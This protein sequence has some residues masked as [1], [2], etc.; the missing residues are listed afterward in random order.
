MSNS[1]RR[2]ARLF[3]ALLSFSI[4][5]ATFAGSI[6]A[7]AFA[8]EA[9]PSPTAEPSEPSPT[10]E[11]SPTTD[12]SP[13]DDPAPSEE[14]SPTEDPLPTEDPSPTEEPSPTGDPGPECDFSNP[15]AGP[16][17][18]SIASDLAD[19]PPG[20]EVTLTAA[21]FA[22]GESVC[23]RVNE[24]NPTETWSL[25]QTLSAAADGTLVFSFNLPDY[26]IAQYR[27]RAWGLESGA[28]AETTFTDSAGSYD[29]DFAAADPGDSPTYVK[30]T[31]AQFGAC[32]APS[33][34]TGRASDPMANAI[35]G[36]PKDAV[37][38]L[39]PDDM[40]L[41]QI[42]PFELDIDVDGSTSPET[43]K[44][45]I[46][47]DHAMFTTNGDNFG[48][49]S[50]FGVYCAFIDTNDTRN[51]NMDGDEKVVAFSSSVVGAGTNQEI[52]GSYNIS[53]LQDNDRVVLEIW[54]VLKSTI[55]AG[56]GGNVQSELFDADTCPTQSG[57]TGCSASGPNNPANISTG[58]QTVPLLQVGQ[59]FSSDANLGVTKT[60]SPDP[61]TAGNNLTYTIQVT[62]AGPDTAN[63]IVVTDVLDPNT[64]YVSS[65]IPCTGTTTLT[66]NAGNLVNGGSTSFTITVNVATGA[67]SGTTPGTSSIGGTCTVGSQDLCNVVSVDAINDDPT[68]GNNSDSEPTNVL[69]ANGS[70]QIL[71]YEDHDGNGSR[72]ADGADNAVGGG[73]DEGPL[74]GWTIFYD[75]NG[76]GQNDD[77]I[78][79]STDAS[80][81]VTLSGIPAGSASICEVLQSGWE[82]TDPGTVCQTVTVSGGGTTNEQFGNASADLA[83]DKTGPTTAQAGGV[84]EWTITVTNGG[85]SVATDAIADDSL[86][87]GVTNGRFCLPATSDCSMEANY[88][89]IPGS[90][91]I[92]LGDLS[93]GAYT[94][95]VRADVPGDTDDGTELENC[96]AVSSDTEDP[97]SNDLSDCHTTVVDNLPS[98]TVV[99]T[100][101]DAADGDTYSISEPGGTVTYTVTITNN[102]GEAVTLESLSDNVYGNL[103]DDAGNGLISNADCDQIGSIAPGATENC[104][105]DTSFT[106]DAGDS[107]VDTVTATTDDGEGN[108]ATDSD[109][110]TVTI[111]DDL[112]TV[113]VDKTADPIEVSEPG[114]EITYTYTVTNTSADESVTI[115]SLEDDVLGPL[116]GD[117]DCQVGTVLAAGANCSFT[118]TGN[119]AGT[120]GD[121][122]TNVFT[123]VVSDDNNNTDDDTDDATVTITD[124]LPTVDVDKTADPIEV[125]EPGGEITYTYTVTN[126]SADESVT[127]DSLED[128]VLG[129][130]AGDADCQ[131]G[132]VLAA[133]ANCSFT[134]TGNVAGTG[135]DSVTNVFT[136]VVSDDNNNT[137]DD[138]D[139]ATV[140]ITDDLPTVDVDKTAD[141]IEVSEP[142]GEITY[143]YTVTNTSADESV[144]IDSLEDDVLGPL[145]GDA[146]CQVGTVLAAGAN[147]SFTATGNVAGTGGDS[148]T[149]VFTAVV[150]DDNNNTDDDTD[151]ATVTITDDLPTVDVDKTADPIEVSEP[152]GEITY[153]YTVTNTSADES[154][155]ID[156]LEDDVLGPLAGDADCQVGTVLAAGANCSFTA[157]GNVAGTGGDSVTNV[158]TAVVSDD[159]NNTDDD[160]DDATV[161]ITDDLPTVDVDKTADPIE[162]SEPGGEITYTYTVTNTSADE[163]VTIDSLEDDVLGPLAGDADCQVGTVLAAGANCSFT[164]TGNVAG[165]G[166]DSVTNVFT[167][168]VSDDNN[169]T[170][171][172]TDDATVTIT[173]DLPTVDVDKTADPI[174][175]SEP[176]GEITYTY[177]VTNTSADESV[178]ID[179]LEDDVLGP[180]AGDADCQVGTVLAAGANCSFTA[181]GN[182]AGTGGDSVTNVFTAVVSDDN[183]NTDDDTDDA[184]VT[185]TDDLPTVDV[186]KTADPIEVSEPGGEITYTYTVT[187]TSADESVTI[188]SLEDDVLGPLAGDAD[189]QV[190][191]V[192]AAGANCSFTATGNVA[193]TGGDSVTNVFTAVVSDD[194]NN[195]DDDTDDATVTITDDLPTVDVDKTADPIEVSEPGGEITYTYTV[196]NT[197]ADESVTIDSL[198][199]DVLGP[200][201][202]DA[203]CQ[204]GTVLAAG[205]NCSFTATGNVAGTGGD[206]VTNVFTAVVSDD[207]NN[208]DDDTD[209]ATVTITDD[210]PTVDVDKTAD[211]IEV[212]EPGG[213]ITYTYTVTNTSADESVTIDSLEDDVLGPLAGDADCQ[214]G[215][216][217]AAG[218][219]CSFTA[220][221]NVAGTGGDSVTNVFTAVVSDDNNNTDDD[222]DDA[223]VT[224]TDDLPTVD[225]D[226]TADPIE[227]SEPGGEITYTY[228]VTNTSADESVTIDSLED[229][230]LGPLAGDADCQVGTVLAA[231]ANC[232]FTATGNVAGTGGDSVT[233]VFT[234]V[235]SDDNNNTDDDTDDAT[236]TITDDLPTVDVD[237][238]ADPIEVS[239]P[240]G[241]ITYTYTVTNTSA[242]ESVTIDSLED[243]VLGPLAG[244]ADCQVGTVL[245]AGANCS[246]T[247]TGNVAGTGGDSVTNVFTAV[248]SDDN[249][250]TDDDTDDATVTITD[251]L[252]TV[253]VDKT[254]DP[255]EVSEPGGEI[256]YTYTVT[257]T[258]ADESVTIDSLEDDVLGPLAGDAD[259]QVGTV[260]AAGANCSF[261][262]TGNVAGTG[263]DS[264]TNVFTAVVSDDNNNTDDDTDD[265]TVTIT[266]DLPTVDV[267]KTADPI[268][269]SEPGGEITYTYTVT[270]T[271]ADESVTI[272]SL[273]DDVLGPLAGDADCQVGTVLA[274][275]AN[276]SFTA[277]GNVAGTGG[278]SVTNVF[279]AVVSDDNNNTDDDTD[280]ATVTITD[281]LP[282]VDVDKTAD[283]IEV[284]E[285]GGEITY[286]YTVT[287]TSA[288]ESVTIDSLED[289][290]LGPLAGDADCQVGTV[291]AAGANCSFTATGNVAGTGGDSVTNVFTAVV[292]DDNN[293]TDD[294]TDD[295][296][297]TITDDLPTVDVDK[298][299]DPI[300]VSEP[301]GEITYTYTVTNTSADESVTIDSLED[302]VLGPLAGDADCQV[303]TVLAAGAN[304]SFTATGNVAG[305]GGDSVTNVFTAVV[306]DDNNNTDDDT[307]DATVTITDELPDISVEK[308][309]NPTSVPL[310]GGNVTFTIQVTNDSVEPVTL[311]VLNDSVFGNL[312]GRG[313]CD[314][315]Q[316]IAANGGTYT[317]SFVVFVTPTFNYAGQ[318]KAHRNVVTATA[319]D[320]EG[321]RDT[322]TDDAEVLFTW[323]GRT[324][325]YWKNHPTSWPNPYLT[326]Q[327]VQDVFT[328]PSCLKNAAGN[329]DLTKPSGKDT[330][331]QAL[332]YQGGTNLKGKAQ[333]LLR[334]AVA[335]LLNE[336]LFGADYPPHA[337]TTALIQDVNA[338][339]ATCNGGQY[340]TK[341]AVLDFWNNGIH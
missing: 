16:A 147:C 248:V 168:V 97:D 96:V 101:G 149:N 104:T 157:T 214:V 273:E 130:L 313:N 205:A 9:D 218:A 241:E 121:S 252:P 177:T 332:D 300:E 40:I 219:N 32:P 132:T 253:D 80:G 254:A 137:D 30:Q 283:P 337:S 22:P 100:A 93:P 37:E 172:D 286:T 261:T 112:P 211:P 166:G 24:D 141:P 341:A 210:L 107:V 164:A 269:V 34:G 138:T 220:T 43:G 41:G 191:T 303:G 327:K 73:D 190:G 95:R 163:S 90:G 305:T 307:D 209:D 200:L 338:T 69:A 328:I 274:A 136:A 125:S 198:E 199:D 319:V 102:S 216:V 74:Q 306:S 194:N 181:T 270:N 236:V 294:D 179:S 161:T 123:A 228:T 10:E 323:R 188:D 292:S 110:A 145:A 272:D 196:T 117:A 299:A 204:V 301:G 57:S 99:K 142:G 54:L 151:D 7:T 170:D 108:D 143:T 31:P 265:A 115:D 193:G 148:V 45:R 85:P 68:A 165:T 215:T 255:I 35:F 247:A 229:D 271:S 316:T 28:Y 263:G 2:S 12:P 304:C 11:P 260:L 208:T 278:D 146:D 250:N 178:T 321:N 224:I 150:S 333:I 159:N 290:V 58:N 92:S 207:N 153:T 189:C 5:V 44:I 280:D 291:L 75:A 251:D 293:N 336:R 296:T 51:A 288:D 234:A 276:C 128:D 127:I 232:S 18:A 3:A 279:T 13:T 238:T 62:N 119:V 225:V 19:Y 87:A 106:G 184:T 320:D 15:P 70:V 113:D 14:P 173:D 267:D 88:T 144:T 55:P 183:N 72:D 105:F 49:D 4:V 124:D 6:S 59:F 222:T 56:T 259:C 335:G 308:T 324:P 195:T 140:T 314:V 83:V 285:P 133:G 256:T 94:V 221:G 326:T 317:C 334:A 1:N 23:L 77:A 27:V 61:V 76:N 160:T 169:N 47:T 79:G 297:V 331:I 71:K 154:V 226:K 98:I 86:P 120:G 187:N 298:T 46:Q 237:K 266:D 185:I 116:A 64:S 309:A 203:D 233:N 330:L 186:D 33:G 202:G 340:T 277:T 162:V 258:S 103:L 53:G 81:L 243:D 167:A 126:T 180:L 8:Q 244:D 21:G 20:A 48:Y 84:I 129:P 175:V 91:E 66:C 111:T 239:E 135:G 295:A 264:V 52:R 182:V 78:S 315:P 339:L 67:P 171:D 152:G 134:A 122:V 29:L 50:T 318:P 246:F 223:T 230:V 312:D 139:D 176:G 89:S 212:S 82:N 118:A 245:A 281:D 65:S 257:N 63:G 268:E 287:N 158:F 329:L 284:S 156:S 197:S 322:D 310:A 249:N 213:E 42:V 302:D 26:F 289:D 240:G 39:A 227:V 25:R 217:L 131:V 231:G 206:S 311:T 201:A 36:N 174:E 325:G 262:A 235:V 17:T 192:L 275:G 242:D 60:D 38:S 109:D 155:T 114:G 282:T